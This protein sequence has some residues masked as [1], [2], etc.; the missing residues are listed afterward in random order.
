[1]CE[2]VG[3]G[4]KE[5]QFTEEKWKEHKVAGAIY[6]DKNQNRILHMWGN[7]QLW[8]ASIVKDQRQQDM[9]IM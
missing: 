2:S 3:G 9:Q 4:L 6:K 5:G 7:I 8:Y 1:M